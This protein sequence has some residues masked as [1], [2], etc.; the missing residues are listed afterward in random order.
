MVTSLTTS[1]SLAIVPAVWVRGL[2]ASAV[3]AAANTIV[4]LI[5]SVA[6]ASMSV[7]I[8]G[9][10]LAITLPVVLI[11]TILPIALAGAIA[12]L[13]TR[14][15][16]RLRVGLGWAGL[17]FALVTTPV[18]LASAPDPAVGWSLAVMHAIAGIAW[19]AALTIRAPRRR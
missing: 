16:P 10:S 8:Q 18:P 4:F 3:T 15:W 2:I 6:G 5:A 9:T 12:W 19:L 7:A 1:A 17:V 11:T 13:L 14:R